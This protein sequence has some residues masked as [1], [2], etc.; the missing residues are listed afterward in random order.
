MKVSSVVNGAAEPDHRH[1]A[2][3]MRSVFE[4]RTKAREI[5]RRAR[6]AIVGMFSPQVVGAQMDALVQGLLTTEGGSGGR[7]VR[8]GAAKT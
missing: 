5:G 4:D 7:C 6:D 2:Q 8:R 1:L 3:L